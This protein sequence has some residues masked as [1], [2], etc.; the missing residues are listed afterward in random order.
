MA[1]GA[2][3]PLPTVMAVPVVLLVEVGIGVT[4]S[5]P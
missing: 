1:N 2:L 4:V 5:E 3:S